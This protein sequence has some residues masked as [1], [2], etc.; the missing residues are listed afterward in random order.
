MK[1]EEVMRKA[2]A[3]AQAQLSNYKT[4]DVQATATVVLQ[5]P[6]KDSAPRQTNQSSAQAGKSTEAR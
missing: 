4:L 3:L 6:I 5:R 2:L 1:T